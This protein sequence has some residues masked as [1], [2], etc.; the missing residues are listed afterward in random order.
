[1]VL[2]IGSFFIYDVWGWAF[3]LPIFQE[4]VKFVGILEGFDVQ[5]RVWWGDFDEENSGIGRW[6]E[7]VDQFLFKNDGEI[8]I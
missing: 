7:E 2:G 8:L 4:L 1:M 3:S 6:E 5:E